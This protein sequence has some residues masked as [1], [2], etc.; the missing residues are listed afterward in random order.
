MKMLLFC[1]VLLT[2]AFLSAAP[3]YEINFGS[4]GGLPSMRI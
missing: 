3:Q 2:G 1:W 4:S